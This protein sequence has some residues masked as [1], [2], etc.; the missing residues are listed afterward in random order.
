MY[1]S[2]IS[3]RISLWYDSSI[4]FYNIVIAKSKTKVVVPSR[5]KKLL[6]NSALAVYGILDDWYFIISY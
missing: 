1:L 2:L 6:S 5:Y 4:A 3:L